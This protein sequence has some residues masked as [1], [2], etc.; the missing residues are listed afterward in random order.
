MY[1]F[2]SNEE[3]SLNGNGTLEA[4]HLINNIN[5]HFNR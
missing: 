5:T 1:K 2:K 3:N 4:N